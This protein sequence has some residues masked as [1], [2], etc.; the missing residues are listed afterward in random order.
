MSNKPTIYS[1]EKIK[2]LAMVQAT[3][4]EYGIKMLADCLGVNP[5]TV[6]SDV[7]PKSIGR[8]TNKLGY[9]DW[10]VILDESRDFSSLDATN[11][12]FDRVCLPI[13]KPAD[14]M[15]VI[16]WMEH[17]AKTAKESGEAIAQLAEAI[18]DGRMEDEELERCEKE[19]NEALEAHAG[20]YL[21]IKT[22]RANRN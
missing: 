19:N 13:P 16:D 21:A 8:R 1:T 17:C 12:L 18:L 7:D 22:A 4:K 5:S 11:L 2:V 15:T 9:L 14:E 6:Y 3:A 10:L 20:L